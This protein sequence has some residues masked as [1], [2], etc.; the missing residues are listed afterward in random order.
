MTYSILPKKP[1]KTPQTPSFV[2]PCYMFRWTLSCPTTPKPLDIL[3]DFECTYFQTEAEQGTSRGHFCVWRDPCLDDYC[4]LQAAR[5]KHSADILTAVPQ[6][7]EGRDE[8]PDDRLSP[9]R[10]VSRHECQWGGEHCVSHSLPS[11]SLLPATPLSSTWETLPS[12]R[13]KHDV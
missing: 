11:T 10:W 2:H 9:T 8:S 4:G 1:T 3:S 5:C 12:Q 7:S 6:V 13:Y